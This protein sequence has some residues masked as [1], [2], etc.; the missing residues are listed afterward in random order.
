MTGTM[1][2]PDARSRTRTPLLEARNVSKY[3][4]AVVALDDV[5]LAV[6]AGEVV[7]LIGANGAGKSTL[8]KLLSGVFEPD[9]GT[10]AVDGK[11]VRFGS[12]RGFA[13]AGVAVYQDL[14]V[15]PLMSVGELLPR[16]RADLGWRAVQAVRCGD[17]R[18]APERCTGSGSTSGTRTRPS[19][20]C[21]GNDRRSRSHGPSTSARGS[22]SST[23]RPPP[24][25]SG[26]RDRP[27]ASSRPG[28]RRQGHLH[29]PQHQHALPVGDVHDPVASRRHVQAGRARRQ[30][31]PPAHGGGGELAA[32][33]GTALLSTQMAIDET[34]PAEAAVSPSGSDAGVAMGGR[35]MSE[36]ARCR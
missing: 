22:S 32:S 11:T 30:P 15:M 36:D 14:A 27:A 21:R 24:W 8:I 10:L 33:G 34:A 2:A 31:A 18:D 7:C 29:H 13:D 9:E 26:I 4:G 6:H 23:S 3:F 17:D 25:A 20:H 28:Y 12:P 5:S 1:A 19:A 35:A 16:Q